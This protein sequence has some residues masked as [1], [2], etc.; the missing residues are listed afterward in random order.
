M[1][2]NRMFHA[3][4]R[5]FSP[6]PEQLRAQALYA[7]LV[8]LSRR[9]YFYTQCGVPDTLDG[10]FEMILLHLF[11]MLKR[12]KAESDPASDALV[13]Q[14]SESFVDDMDRSLRE[15]GV[16]DT[17]VGKRVKRMA[18]AF[19]GRLQA[20]E[21]ALASD[22]ALME[23]LTRNAYGTVQAQPEQ[24]QALLQVVRGA[25]QALAAA[26]VATILAQLEA[27]FSHR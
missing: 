8:E 12:L 14:L 17:G 26:P 7:Q 5:L 22:E 27:Y 6:S 1:P 18:V 9:P 3:V 13:R 2:R 24:V 4:R 23:A 10:R 19:Y 16:T 25:D 20:Y 21:D 11:L 15:I